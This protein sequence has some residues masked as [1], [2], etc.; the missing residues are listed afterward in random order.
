MVGMGEKKSSSERWDQHGCYKTTQVIVLAT[1]V[2]YQQERWQ[3]FECE[4]LW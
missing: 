4:G 1:Y 3:H 2:H